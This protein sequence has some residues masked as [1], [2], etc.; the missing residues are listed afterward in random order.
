MRFQTKL[1]IPCIYCLE[2]CISYVGTIWSIVVRLLCSISLERTYISVFSF[3]I[4]FFFCNIM[5]IDVWKLFYTLLPFTTF[6]QKYICMFE[7][8][9]CSTLNWS[10]IVQ[11]SF[12]FTHVLKIISLFIIIFS[13]LQNKFR[14]FKH[15]LLQFECIH[16]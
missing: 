11:L 15:V 2:F 13:L 9:F 5:M 6:L 16:M 10:Q 7:T 14:F 8:V 3:F 4:F 12:M 1:T